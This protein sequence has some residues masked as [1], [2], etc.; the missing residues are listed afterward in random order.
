MFGAGVISDFLWSTVLFLYDKVTFLKSLDVLP[1]HTRWKNEYLNPSAFLQRVARRSFLSI[2]VRG[3]PLW[4]V[5]SPGWWQTQWVCVGCETV[6]GQKPGPAAEPLP[7]RSVLWEDSLP[8]GGATAREADPYGEEQ[9]S[10]VFSQKKNTQLSLLCHVL[11]TAF[12]I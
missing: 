3:Q 1:F 10:Y 2:R 5:P 6:S 9:A 11:K 8:T 12:K 4:Q 7:R